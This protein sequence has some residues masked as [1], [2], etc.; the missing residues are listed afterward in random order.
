MLAG[1]DGPG[2]IG[3]VLHSDKAGTEALHF[4]SKHKQIQKQT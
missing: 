2:Y 3:G 4:C 1:N